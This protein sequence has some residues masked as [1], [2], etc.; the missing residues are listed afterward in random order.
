MC[1]ILTLFHTVISKYL[2]RDP[3]C[4]LLVGS[5]RV[6]VDNG[7]CLCAVT[8]DSPLGALAFGVDAVEDGASE[9]GVTSHGMVVHKPYID[10]TSV[11]VC[12]VKRVLCALFEHQSPSGVWGPWLGIVLLCALCVASLTLAWSCVWSFV[13]FDHG[14]V[15]SACQ[16]DQRRP[17]G[18]RSG[19]IRSVCSPC[20]ASKRHSST[21]TPSS[22]TRIPPTNAP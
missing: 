19:I 15:L 2:A 18:R 21:H 10:H 9:S 22:S 14:V 1:E 11:G 7:A 6:S 16:S 13:L 17:T 8:R 5:A 20:T 3:T 12:V 4:A